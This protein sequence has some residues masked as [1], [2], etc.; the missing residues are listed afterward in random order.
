MSW[1]VEIEVVGEEQADAIVSILDNAADEVDLEF[2]FTTS[3][4][5]SDDEARM[6][7][8]EYFDKHMGQ[9]KFDSSIAMGDEIPIESVCGNDCKNAIDAAANLRRH[10]IATGSEEDDNVQAVLEACWE[11]CQI[12]ITG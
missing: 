11:V 4:T 3:K 8:Q 6:N 1:K 7:V 12:Y 5:G 2:G 10:V 9:A